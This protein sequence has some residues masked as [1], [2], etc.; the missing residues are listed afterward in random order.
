MDGNLPIFFMELFCPVSFYTS[1]Q[2]R[3]ARWG[4]WDLSYCPSVWSG[5]SKQQRQSVFH[6]YFWWMNWLNKLW[7]KTYFQWDSEWWNHGLGLEVWNK[8]FVWGQK[9]KVWT[10]VFNSSDFIWSQWFLEVIIF[11]DQISAHSYSLAGNELCCG[12]LL[13][14]A[15]G[16]WQIHPAPY[17]GMCGQGSGLCW[18]KWK[19]LALLSSVCFHMWCVV[20]L[21]C[22]FYL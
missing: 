21:A 3:L 8:N 6:A 11:C 4:N 15:A 5:A 14:C 18:W 20:Y 22:L 12:L 10:F 19:P 13:G 7:G 1:N 17:C 2:K 16:F 9:S